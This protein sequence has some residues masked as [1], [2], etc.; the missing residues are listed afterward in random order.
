MEAEEET[1]ASV[2][3][4]STQESLLHLAR[5]RWRPVVVGVVLGLLAAGAS[6]VVAGPRW[7]SEASV[8][9]TPTG[10]A[11]AGQV[12]NGQSSSSQLN[13][14]TEAE[15][16]TSTAVTDRIRST[17]GTDLSTEDLIEA[18]GIEVPPNTSILQITYADDSAGAAREGAQAFAEAYLAARAASAEDTIGEQ[19]AALEEQIATAE[20]ELQT[21]VGAASTAR[22]GSP[23]AAV[24]ESQADV[25][26]EQLS[27]LNRRLADLNATTVTPGRIIVSAQAPTS[28]SGLPPALLVAAGLFL[29]AALG[30]GLAL[31]RDRSDQ[32]IRR[33]EDVERVADLP[34]FTIGNSSP[35]GRRTRQ[36]PS[37]ADTRREL[38]RLR[39][40]LMSSLPAGRRTVL[41]AA[42]GTSTAAP[43]VAHGVAT[44]LADAENT[45]TLVAADAGAAPVLRAVTGDAGPGLADVLV[46]RRG[47]AD[48]VRP[49]AHVPSLGVLP[50]GSDAAGLSERLQS[51]QAAEVLTT[52]R[53]A[54]DFVVVQAPSFTASA[55]AQTIGR[56]ADAAILVLET[57][58]PR[59]ADLEDALT[60]LAQVGVTDVWIVLVPR[61]DRTPAVGG[62][63]SEEAAENRAPAA[64]PGPGV[65]DAGVASRGRPTAR[66]GVR[67]VPAA[68][69]RDTA[70][71]ES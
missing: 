58:R 41:V 48:A 28:P 52:L 12:A 34:A 70:S 8:L 2:P 42:V 31:V 7:T 38:H 20:Q 71:A 65:G 60:Q 67:T 68:P 53:G 61:Q 13:L 43:S 46:G 15:L 57:G 64:D 45:V 47:L 50:P 32:R 18:V 21:A 24:A 11:D 56:T 16:V 26:T 44:A 6:I 39:N 36:E 25:L 51:R 62:A 63:V 49:A 30:I 17:P 29:G 33:R 69:E 1:M 9:V 55:D 35:T 10:V 14:Q 5:R 27:T 19:V 23:E 40:A 37:P 4:P 22:A 59:I 54:S 66:D 3:V